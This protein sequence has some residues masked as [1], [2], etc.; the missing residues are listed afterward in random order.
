MAAALRSGLLEFL[1]CFDSGFASGSEVYSSVNKTSVIRT[2]KEHT[3][4]FMYALT[5]VKPKPDESKQ[6]TTNRV[7]WQGGRVGFAELESVSLVVSVLSRTANSVPCTV[8][9]IV[10]PVSPMGA[11]HTNTRPY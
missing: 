8:V 5:I 9:L 11:A 3:A 2:K 6:D 1:G 10:D 4:C 7:E